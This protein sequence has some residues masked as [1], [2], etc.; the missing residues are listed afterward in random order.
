MI[1]FIDHKDFKYLSDYLKSNY[2][3]DP[4]RF[5]ASYI[6]RKIPQV[7]GILKVNDV[8]DM[9]SRYQNDPSF[10]N[11]LIKLLYPD[12]S[13]LLRDPD[14]WSYLMK[15]VI[16]DFIKSKNKISIYFPDFT[17]GD[18]L[19]SLILLIGLNYPDTKNFKIYASNIVVPEFSDFVRSYF[20]DNKKFKL[21]ESNYLKLTG[22][23]DF[24]SFFRLINKR[25]YLE[26][27]F[28]READVRLVNSDILKNDLDQKFDFVFYRNKML[29]YA[30]E[31][32]PKVMASI[33]FRLNPGGYL[34]TGIRDSDFSDYFEPVNKEMNLYRRRDA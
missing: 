27:H 6:Y 13:E 16:D 10:I 24:L 8:Y 1:R 19:I 25:Y 30:T 20:V 3:F 23:D 18:D 31:C 11:T 5:T 22:K 17:N 7:L 29:Y 4:N 15:P 32:I 26:S 34:I 12:E 28:V 21:S 9:L 33:K 14:V 2:Q